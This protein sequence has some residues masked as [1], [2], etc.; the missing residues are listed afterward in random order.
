MK[1]T[2]SE[3]FVSALI[4]VNVDSIASFPAAAHHMP[5]SVSSAMYYAHPVPAVL[6]QAKCDDIFA[7]ANPCVW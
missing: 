1:T 5:A 7:C 6:K 2:R 3:P 4:E